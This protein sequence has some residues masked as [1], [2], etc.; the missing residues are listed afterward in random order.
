MFKCNNGKEKDEVAC[1]QVSPYNE[2]IVFSS[3]EISGIKDNGSK[4][5]GQITKIK[6]KNN[7][8]M[9]TK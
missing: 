6:I 4:K 9:K 1:S 7:S 5:L 2:T 8:R 3:L